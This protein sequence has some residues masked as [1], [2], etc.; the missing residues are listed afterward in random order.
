MSQIEIIARSKDQAFEKAAKKLDVTPEELT[1]LEEYDPDDLDLK[2]LEKEEADFPEYKNDGEPILFVISINMDKAIIQIREWLEGL[3]SRFQKGI[4]VEMIYEEGV[5]TAVFHADDPSILIGRQG[6]TLE[7]LQH[8][9]T[10]ILPRIVPNCPI[11]QLDVGDYREKRLEKLEEIAD[12]AVE[13]ALRFK[14]NVDLRPMSSQDRKY[15]HNYLKDEPGIKTNSYGAEPNRYL[16]IEVPG[17]DKARREGARRGD[18]KD[19]PQDRSRGGDSR[20][21]REKNG[22]LIENK[23][24]RKKDANGNRADAPGP[25]QEYFYRS[26][27]QEQPKKVTIEQMLE[28]LPKDAD[29]DVYEGDEFYEDDVEGEGYEYNADDD[30]DDEEDD[31]SR[32][33]G[34]RKM[35]DELE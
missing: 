1:V 33:K 7:A 12:R 32:P 31:D 11:I 8:I 19:R 4:R 21:N 22:N 23:P 5:A 10:R 29:D 17:G 34:G 15:V 27:P 18:R 30:Q 28:R 9:V 25:K 2:N 14:R 26:E 3:M 13:K 24:A 20:G 16:A 35:I 6:Q